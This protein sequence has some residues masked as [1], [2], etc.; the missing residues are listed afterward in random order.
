M[1]EPV[2]QVTHPALT[3]IAQRPDLFQRQGAVVAT[4][5]REGERK[6]GPYYQLAY[7]EDGRQHWGYLGV[8]GL[9]VDAVREVLDRL[10]RVLRQHRV[11]KRFE[12]QAMASLRVCKAQLNAQLQAVGLQLKGFKVRGW[13]TSDYGRMLN[14]VFKQSL[15]PSRPPA[16][17]P[18]APSPHPLPPQT[19]AAMFRVLGLQLPTLPR[20]PTPP[21]P[22]RLVRQTLGSVEAGLRSLMPKLPR[23]SLCGVRIM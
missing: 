19:P 9:V 6:R 16:A 20:L 8:A 21:S 11:L 1:D 18:E 7:R 15:K 4:W 13:R 5:R 3:L 10:Q 12:Q 17:P 14:Q 2:N 23:M 22:A